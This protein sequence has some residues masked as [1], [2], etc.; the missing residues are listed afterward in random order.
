MASPVSGVWGE[1]LV[2]S[3]VHGGGWLVR[4]VVHGCV[5]SPVSG[6]WVCG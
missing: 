2:R 4:S 5:A 1:W 6:A 3:V